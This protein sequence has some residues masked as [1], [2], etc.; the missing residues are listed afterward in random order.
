MWQVGVAM[1]RFDDG[2][3]TV[4]CTVLSRCPETVPNDRR[5]ISALA[6]RRLG[7]LSTKRW[8][9]CSHRQ[10]IKGSFCGCDCNIPLMPTRAILSNHVFRLSGAQATPSGQQPPLLSNYIPYHIL[11]SMAS[12]TFMEAPCLRLKD[13]FFPVEAKR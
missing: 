1:L 9:S 11:I 12:Y 4:I 10:S 6:S 8:T 13:R 2:C 3:G 7:G 5:F